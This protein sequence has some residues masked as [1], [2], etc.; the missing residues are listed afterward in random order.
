M[1]AWLVWLRGLRGP[2]AE[3]WRDDHIDIYRNRSETRVL[4]LHPL[5][6]S[7]AGEPI[8]YLVRKYQPPS[9]ED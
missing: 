1:S 4:R 8:S 9:N 6:A 2:T 5:T 3:I 7:E